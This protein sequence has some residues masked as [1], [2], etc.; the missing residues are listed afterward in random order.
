MTPIKWHGVA[1]KFVISRL[2]T[3]YYGLFSFPYFHPEAVLKV[4][5]SLQPTVAFSGFSEPEEFLR[6][7]PHNNL[8]SAF[9]SSSLHS[10]SSSL[11]PLHYREGTS[12]QSQPALGRARHHHNRRCGQ[13]RLSPGDCTY[14][15][16]RPPFR[17]P[18]S[19]MLLWLRLGVGTFRNWRIL[20]SKH[21]EESLQQ[22]VVGECGDA[23]IEPTTPSSGHSKPTPRSIPANPATVSQSVRPTSSTLHYKTTTSFLATLSMHNNS[24]TFLQ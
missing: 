5:V 4:V 15:E 3:F 9:S 2:L 14:C 23:P 10:T 6:S 8:T 19:D 20:F 12:R 11:H 16:M 21:L 7:F 18:E 1:T 13:S 24:A 17:S 22:C